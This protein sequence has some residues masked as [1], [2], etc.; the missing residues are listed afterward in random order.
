M[1]HNVLHLK[2]LPGS[3][4][5]LYTTKCFFKVGKGG[6]LFLAGGDFPPLS[7]HV[8]WKAK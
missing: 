4:C 2:L 1:A 6:E 7:S 3:Y 8:F 5:I